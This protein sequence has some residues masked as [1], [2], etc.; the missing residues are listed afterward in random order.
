MDPWLERPFLFP[1]FHDGF[2]TYLR[3]ALSARLPRGYAVTAGSRVYV[4]PELRRVPDLGVFGPPGAAAAAVLTRVGMLAA[5]A[6][7]MSDPVTEAYLE[8]LSGEDDRLVTVIEM[9]SPANKAAGENARGAYRHKQAECRYGG[10]N[11]VELD[12]LRGGA[13]TT[14]VSA[15]RLRAVA[16]SGYDY[17]V[18]VFMAGEPGGVFVAPFRLTDRLPTI[19]VPLGADADPVPIDL[20]PVFDRCYDEGGFDRLM[21]YDR[22]QPDPPLAPEPRAWADGILREKGLVP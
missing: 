11:L 7:P 9:L 2:L 3:A 20:Q 6:D 13:H 4:D 8:I 19:A 15:A 10:V 21:K 18:S 1:G 12:L 14:V 5:A 17:H 22:Q 16:P